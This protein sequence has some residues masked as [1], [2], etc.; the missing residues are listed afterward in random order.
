[1]F[2]IKSELEM[3]LVEHNYLTAVGLTKCPFSLH[4]VAVLSLGNC[5]PSVFHHLSSSAMCDDTVF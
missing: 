1:M 2:T 5:L 3:S 4:T